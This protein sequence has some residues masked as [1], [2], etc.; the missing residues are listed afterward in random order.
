MLLAQRCQFGQKQFRSAIGIMHGQPLDALPACNV[1]ASAKKACNGT[2]EDMLVNN[3]LGN[4][5]VEACRQ[6]G[7]TVTGHGMSRQSDHGNTPQEWISL[8]APQDLCPIHLRKRDVEKDEV[9]LFVLKSSQCLRTRFIG[10]DLIE[11]LEHGLEEQEIIRIIFND[12]N[13]PHVP[14]SL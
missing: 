10:R 11:V 3:G 4:I 1:L 12:G 13:L 8:K 7:F 2:E 5:L 6:K 14:N 9:W